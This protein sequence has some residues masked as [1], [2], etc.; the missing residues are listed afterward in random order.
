ML[1]GVVCIQAIGGHCF[2][3]RS[4]DQSIAPQGS[5]PV[6][7]HHNV[8]RGRPFILF[9]TEVAH[10]VCILCIASELLYWVVVTLEQ[11]LSLNCSW[12]VCL[13]TVYCK[14]MKIL[15]LDCFVLIVCSPIP[16]ESYCHLSIFD[17]L[18][19][20][21]FYSDILSMKM[22]FISSAANVCSVESVY[23]NLFSI[24]NKLSQVKWTWLMA[25][26]QMPCE[27]SSMPVITHAIHTF[28]LSK[29][30]IR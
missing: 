5:A 21:P 11:G 26:L 19:C 13:F 18:R 14:T 29:A 20:F 30:L 7:V 6:H 2:Q 15:L 4:A 9:R 8:L 12:Y 3:A 28:H 24:K 1:T 17:S 16:G 23:T 25:V 10:Y 27:P 22:S